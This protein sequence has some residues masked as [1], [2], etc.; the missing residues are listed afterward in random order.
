MVDSIHSLVLKQARREGGVEGV[1]YPG[2]RDVWGSSPSARNIKYA[3]IYHFQ[4]KNSKIFFPEGL[5]ENVWWPSE[6]VFSGPAL[7]LDGPVLT[8]RKHEIS[9]IY[10]M[11]R[12]GHKNVAFYF[13][14][15]L[16]QLLID[17]QNSFTG[18]LCRHCNNMII[19]YPTMP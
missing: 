2:P 10:C 11:Y 12:V 3:R 17:F 9:S 6:N 15:Y 16:R 13:C 4:K 18:T 1:S 14:S 7:A 5:R 8:Y 19:T